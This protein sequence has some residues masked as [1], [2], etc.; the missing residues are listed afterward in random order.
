MGVDHSDCAALL[1]FCD[2]AGCRGD[3]DESGM[4]KTEVNTFGPWKVGRIT[5]NGVA[6]AYHIQNGNC[7]FFVTLPDIK[8]GEA[9][10][11]EAD[12]KKKGFDCERTSIDEFKIF[13]KENK[14]RL[15]KHDPLFMAAIDQY[16]REIKT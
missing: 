9:D 11:Y 2:C 6:L 13:I 8:Q 4:W 7:V 1:G 14:D 5:S 10:L 3:E 15:N 12:L 16:A